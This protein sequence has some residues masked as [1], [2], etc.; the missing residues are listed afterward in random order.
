MTERS[1][2]FHAETKAEAIRRRLIRQQEEL[3]QAEA[4]WR[5][6]QRLDDEMRYR[7]RQAEQE[8]HRSRILNQQLAEIDRARARYLASKKPKELARIERERAEYF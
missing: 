5:E 4:R 8:A 7:A 2:R 1:N 3:R 6:K